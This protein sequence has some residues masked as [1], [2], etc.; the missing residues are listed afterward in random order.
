MLPK[1]PKEEDVLSHGT[2]S[3]VVYQRHTALG[4]AT[5]APN[6]EGSAASVGHGSEA[7]HNGRWRK[8]MYKQLLMPWHSSDGEGGWS[9]QLPELVM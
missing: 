4:D 7:Q 8:P 9:Y 6:A 2:G 3:T 1:V 5:V